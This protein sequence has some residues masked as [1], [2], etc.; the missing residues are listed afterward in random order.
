MGL[1]VGGVM[2]TFDPNKKEK[3]RPDLTLILMV[4]FLLGGVYFMF[5]DDSEKYADESAMYESV[6]QESEAEAKE[7]RDEQYADYYASLTSSAVTYEDAKEYLYTEKMIEGPVADITYAADSYG[8]PTFID[9]GEAYPSNDRVTIVIWEEHLDSLESILNSLEI[10]DIICVEGYVDMY[11]GAPQ[12][13]VTDPSQ[14]IT[15]E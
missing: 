5:F 15:M 9:L 1:I 14:I 4:L 8:S 11:D 6:L 3:S 12:I 10:N 13:E 2:S 7:Y